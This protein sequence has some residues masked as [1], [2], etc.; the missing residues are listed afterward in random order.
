MPGDPLSGRKVG[1]TLDREI[2]KPGAH[3]LDGPLIH[4]TIYPV[5]FLRGDRAEMERQLAW[6]ADNGDAALF[7]QHSDTEAYCVRLREARELSRRAAES[8]APTRDVKLLAALV[9]ARTGDTERVQVAVK[10]L[11]GRNLSTP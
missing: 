4:E 9:L 7:A 6:A 1:E 5:A 3:G 11:E 10:E 2:G 8:L